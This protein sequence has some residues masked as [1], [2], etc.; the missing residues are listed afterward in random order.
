MATFIRQCSL[1]MAIA[2]RARL[3]GF[4]SRLCNLLAITE[5]KQF[6]LSDLQFLLLCNGNNNVVIKIK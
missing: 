4:I 5:I 6:K 3:L 2:S 1:V